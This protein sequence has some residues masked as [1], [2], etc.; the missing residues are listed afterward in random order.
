MF[1][2]CP[3]DCR[4]QP[5]S[6]R[7]KK[8]TRARIAPIQLPVTPLLRRTA[9]ET[10]T[11]ARVVGTASTPDATTGNGE[12]STL[13]SITAAVRHDPTSSPAGSARGQPFV[14]KPRATRET[15][16]HLPSLAS[17][18]QGIRIR[19]DDKVNQTSCSRSAFCVWAATNRGLQQAHLRTQPASSCDGI[20]RSTVYASAASFCIIVG[21]VRHRRLQ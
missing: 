15:G 18:L 5:P 4:Q 12:D 6:E 3:S 20:H 16:N 13:S 9:A 14:G 10:V 8:S 2:A 21:A 17:M 7:K 11:R 19:G 1:F